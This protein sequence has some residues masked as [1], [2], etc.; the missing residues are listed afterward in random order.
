MAKAVAKTKKIAAKSKPSAP[1]RAK[2]PASS[3]R[4]AL[5]KSAAK[6]APKPAGKTAASK[7][8]AEAVEIRQMGVHVRR[9]QGRRQSGPARSAG[10]QGRQSGRDGQS[11]PA[12]ASGLHHSDLGMHV[13]LCPRQNL[14]EGIEG[15][16]R[17][18]AGSCRQAHRQGV[19]R[20][21][22][23][24]AGVGAIRRARFDAGHDGHRAQSR[25]QRQDRGGAGRNVRRSP[26]RL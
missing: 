21:Q 18:G 7:P 4:K 2:A 13:F 11:R 24:A 8:A 12:G 26:L 23:S 22:K 16:G 10:R 6:P 1:A 9:R 25:P 14:S 20:C 5:Q 19:R 3:A 17:K 15:A